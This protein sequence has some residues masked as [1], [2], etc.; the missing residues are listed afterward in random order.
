MIGC[1]WNGSMYFSPRRLS[2][3][4]VE[5]IIAIA[6]IVLA[7]VSLFGVW[8]DPAEP[9]RN[10]EL[11]Y[12]LYSFY[13][14]YALAVGL[15]V[16]RATG[17]GVLPKVLHAVDVILASVFQYLT[18]GPSSPFFIYF[19]FVLFAAALRWGWQATVLTAVVLLSAI[20]GMAVR[21][22]DTTGFLGIAPNRLVIR[23]GYLLVVTL[24]LVYLGQHEERLREEIQHLSRWPKPVGDDWGN[25]V[26]AM[27]RH[28]S[29]IMA[30]DRALVVWSAEDE[31]WLYLASWPSP[32]R[33][34]R[35]E[36][37]F[38]EAFEPREIGDA[39]FM[40][41]GDVRRPG[42]QQVFAAPYPRVW[43]GQAI[44]EVLAPYLAGTGLASSPIRSSHVG[45]RV[46]FSGLTVTPE[47]LPL[48][49]VVGRE[50]G[51]LLDQLYEHEQ[52][53]RLAVAEDRVRLARDLHDGLL[54]SLTAVRLEL[55]TLAGRGNVQ[56]DG[57]RE[58][59]LGAIEQALGI[60]QRE[61]RSFIDELRVTGT[62]S[63]SG[64]SLHQRLNELRQRMTLEWHTPIDIRVTPAG[65]SVPPVVDREVPF[66]VH[67]AIVNAL[68]HGQPTRVVVE[69][70][71]KE[72]ALHI[73]VE[74][75][76]G[77]F[78][79]QGRFDSSALEGIK[80]GPRSLLERVKLLGG[81]V[82]VD[83]SSAGSRVDLLLPL[84]LPN[85]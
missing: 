76:G 35:H 20:A 10:A 49:E 43:R 55:R 2:G 78:P 38:L 36:P 54:Q 82:L 65:L 52:S 21:L 56:D 71:A 31:P 62:S 51:L 73:A 16:W 12:S 18:L 69:L 68:K 40:L 50:V 45:G 6:R 59:R 63:R 41:D 3:A 60:E 84:R 17:S 47:S 1:N 14:V 42:P 27:L 7:S 9:A 61:L 34:E 72:G 19:T 46:F 30:A 75:D 48:V 5:R 64:G 81:D 33:I 29:G 44:P 23:V 85:A 13:V 70:S 77:G 74:D 32:S 28:A 57:H 15:L 67:E 80:G 24:L 53:R 79:F 11:T 26:Q 37:S 25:S 8:W 39:S 58:T 66:M 22:H 4:R 83:S